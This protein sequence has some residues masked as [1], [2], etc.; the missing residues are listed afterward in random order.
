[1]KKLISVM[2]CV[3]M[4]AFTIG[5]STEVLAADSVMYDWENF[6]GKQAAIDAGVIDPGIKQDNDAKKENYP[7][8]VTITNASNHPTAQ[9]GLLEGTVKALM[10]QNRKSLTI[11]NSSAANWAFKVNMNA[12]MLASADDLKMYMCYE[13]SAN[14]TIGVKLSNG[15]SYYLADFN[16]DATNKNVYYHQWNW[17][18][19]AGKTFKQC[20]YGTDATKNITLTADDIKNITSILIWH[21]YDLSDTDINNGIYSRIY[22][23]DVVTVSN[24]DPYEEIA[25]ETSATAQLRIGNLNGIRFITEVNADLVAQAKAEGYTVTMGTLIAPLASG[26]LTLDT[27]PVLDIPTAGWFANQTGE[28]AA[29]IVNIKAANI[30]KDF[31]ARGYVK[32]TK[33]DTTTVYYATQP[34]EGRSLKTVAAA[35]VEDISFFNMLNDAQKEQV[36]TW[37]N[38]K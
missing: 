36:T 26:E 38:A 3:F 7:G 2:L 29:S 21:R 12:T 25:G 18:T 32:L 4:V 28:I 10:I 22:I 23:D 31:V 11:N 13:Y 37:A 1:M 9:N 27:N 6:A 8:I 34:N 5:I 19:F 30:T 17:F 33:D 20:G 16:N 15:N 14:H 24:A 35:C